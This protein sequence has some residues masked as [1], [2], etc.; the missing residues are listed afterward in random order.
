[1]IRRT[2]ACG[3]TIVAADLDGWTVWLDSR[4]ADGGLF[5]IVVDNDIPWVAVDMNG[6]YRR[7][8]CMSDRL[9]ERLRRQTWN[10]TGAP[11]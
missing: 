4:P 10:L 9:V 7:H 3:A 1:M 2:C 8:T 11:R 5:R 6:T